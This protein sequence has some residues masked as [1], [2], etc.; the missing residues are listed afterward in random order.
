[1]ELT[2][3][4]DVTRP[5]QV[6]VNLAA[7]SHNY[8]ELCRLAQSAKVMPVVKANAYGHGLVQVAQHLEELHPPYFGVA[9]FEEAIILRDAGIK[10]PIL[11]F[12]GMYDAQIPN[13]IRRDLALTASSISKL[14]A[15]DK[16]GRELGICPEVHLKIDTGM[17]RVGVH[18][19]NASH[20]IDAALQCSNVKIKG[21]YTHFAT[22]DE[23]DESFTQLQLKRFKSMKQYALERM[24]GPLLFHAANS[25]ATLKY[26]S[27]H[28]DMVRVGISLYGVPPSPEIKPAVDLRPAMSWHSKVVYFKVVRA[29]DTVSYG[30]AWSPTEDTRVV[31]VPVGYADGYSRSLSNKARVRIN[32][33]D[34]PVVGK[35]CMDQFMV[36]IGEDSAF[37][38]DKVTLL[39]SGIDAHRL[40]QWRSTIAYEVLTTI[41]ERVPRAYTFDNSSVE[42]PCIESESKYE[43]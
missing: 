6:T 17:E 25:A 36:D 27:T 21:I 5:T 23:A 30:R 7:I 35:I 33:R 18:H 20:L 37:N 24:R 8:R 13:Y 3:P 2:R 1:Q 29:G 26:P 32:G 31:T 43:C 15:I 42:S 40:A 11:V 10:T 14:R 19:Y 12:G 16:A 41:G 38:G 22:A 28:F 34:Y 9:T 4:E 39:G